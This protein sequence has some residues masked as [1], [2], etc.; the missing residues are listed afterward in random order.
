MEGAMRSGW[1]LAIALT[2]AALVAHGAELVTDG[3]VHSVV[4]PNANSGP[5]TVAVAPDGRV[6]FTEGSGN[7]IGRMNADGTGI[8][9]F[10]LPQPSSAPRIIALGADGNMWFSEHSG[11]RMSRITA[12]GVISSFPIPT[13]AS[14]PRAIAL[15]ADGNIWFGEFAS[16]KVGRITPQG[17]I[18]EFA[19]P[20]PDSGPRA[21]AAGPDGNVWVS[22]FRASR[23][24]RITP[25]GE[26]TE[27]PLPR[28]NSGPGDIT[29]G[30]D[31]AMWFV[32]LSGNMDGVQADGARVGRITM[33]GKITEFAL[34][35]KSPSPINIA[36]GPDRNIWYTRGSKVGRVTPEGKITEFELGEGVRGSGLSAG[37]DR[38]PPVRLGNRL[39][40]A[41]GGGNRILWLQFEAVKSPP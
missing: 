37:S 17:E 34:P 3:R 8:V 40:V 7:R 30:A 5:T 35:E 31:G 2:A 21:L 16:G 10:P 29:A 32:E 20:T 18:T 28:P 22:Q 6:W 1:Q 12:E 36:V 13:P 33:E 27:F 25:K 4:L 11:N 41:D 19:L 9:E 14:Q 24:A 39:Y 15:G 23:I 26:I 38:Q